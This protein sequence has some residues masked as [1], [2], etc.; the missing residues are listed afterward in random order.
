MC[1]NVKHKIDMI[2]G[3]IILNKVNG[4]IFR[5][6][7][8]SFR[9]R[10][11]SL[12]LILIS[13]VMGASIASSFLVVAQEISNKIARELR[14]YG[15]NIV[16]E[17]NEGTAS[18]AGESS[19]GGTVSE[20][21]RYLNEQDVPRI[22]AIF[23]RHNIV[24]FTPYIYGVVNV[25]AL[26]KQERA[27]L[28]G[29]WFAKSLNIPGQDIPF[30]TGVRSLATWWKVEGRWV[31]DNGDRAILVGIALAR[32]LSLQV[33]D[34]IRLN[35]RGKLL[36]V[37]IS[38]LVTTGGPEEEQIF[39]SLPVAQE[40]LSLPGKVS[41]VQVSA[42][43]VPLDDFGRRDP[44]TMS[45]KEFEKWYCTPYV[46]SVAQQLEE[47]FNGGRAKPVWQIAEAEGKILSKL[48]LVMLLLTVLALL[49]A[50]SIFRLRSNIICLSSFAGLRILFPVSLT[51]FSGCYSPHRGIFIS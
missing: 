32:R 35:Y 23:W 17:P 25:A 47:V 28:V 30:T 21:G 8:G 22:K 48:K 27:V 7:K 49:A 34:T 24:D 37:R 31:S 18:V 1:V 9:N 36:D 10:Y 33:D 5:I 50:I 43:T 12:A 39:T 11:R 15:A 26:G 3:N 16:V 44:K 38:G 46:T 29:T 13:V 51:L 42:I 40:L 19:E 2:F 14:S 45:K 4:M 6:I 41:R 20:R